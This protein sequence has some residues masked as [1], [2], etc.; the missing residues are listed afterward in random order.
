M[1]YTKV[2]Y[3]IVGKKTKTVYNLG[4]SV[5]VKTD[6]YFHYSLKFIMENSGQHILQKL[7]FCF[8]WK[9]EKKLQICKDIKLSKYLSWMNYHFKLI[10]KKI[11]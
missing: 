2:M 7:I 8:A 5:W 6:V 9:K 1:K 10:H 4:L 3:S 11:Q